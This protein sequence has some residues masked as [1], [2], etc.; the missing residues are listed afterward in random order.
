[1]PKSSCYLNPYSI[2]QRIPVVYNDYKLRPILKLEQQ[3]YAPN[4]IVLLN[5]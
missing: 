4:A 2:S 5:K 3:Q 1:M